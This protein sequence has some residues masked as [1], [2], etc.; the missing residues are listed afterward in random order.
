[1]F[2]NIN[3]LLF[4]ITELSFALIQNTSGVGLPVARH[5]SDKSSPS[6]TKTGLVEFIEI[7]GGSKG[8]QKHL[9]QQF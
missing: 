7:S 2:G 1:M 6:T 4:F 9:L 3:L 8:K 5:L